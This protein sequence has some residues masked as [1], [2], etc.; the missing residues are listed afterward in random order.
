LGNA[1]HN[2]KL[3]VKRAKNIHDFL[4]QR[5]KVSPASIQY[6]GAGET[7]RFSENKFRKNRKTELLLVT[8]LP[9]K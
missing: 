2:D 4:V 9:T 3:S 6:I 8:Q 1:E 7:K 5:A